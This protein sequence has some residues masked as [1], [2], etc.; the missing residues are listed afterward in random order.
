[1]VA[2]VAEPG[3]ANEALELDD[4]SLKRSYESYSN[5][6]TLS[7]RITRATAASLM[8]LCSSRRHATRSTASS[9]LS[10]V[11]VEEWKVIQKADVAVGLVVLERSAF[12][13][14][15]FPM[16]WVMWL[17]VKAIAA[18]TPEQIANVPAYVPRVR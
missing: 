2:S 18:Y 14:V 13:A 3:Q 15:P 9:T 1:V 4:L 6:K 17:A 10:Q 16:N 5:V 12:D 11:R 7:S 8:R